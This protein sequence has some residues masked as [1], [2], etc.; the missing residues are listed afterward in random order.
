MDKLWIVAKETYRKNVKSWSF[1][2]MVF[3][4]LVM[5]GVIFAIGYFMG[6]MENGAN[7]GNLGIVNASSQIQEVINQSDT[8]LTLEYLESQDQANQAIKAGDIDGYLLLDDQSSARYYKK[9][10]VD[11]LNI[12]AIQDSLTSYY[13]IESAQKLGLDPN[14]VAQLEGQVF[15]IEDV[16]LKQGD[17]GTVKEESQDMAMNFAKTGIAYV[18]SF[19]VFLFIMNYVGI[20]SQEIAAEKGSRIMEI[21][22]SS[23]TATHHFMGKL[24]GIVMII[25]TQIAA[26]IVLGVVIW[27]VAKSQNL[28]SFL[29]Q[30]PFN[31]VD[32]LSQNKG[33]LGL[34]TVFA[35]TGVFTYT[36]LAGF[37]GSLVSK[38]E[39]VTKLITPITL[40][41]VAGFYIGM[42][43]L[44]NTTNPIVRIGSMFP[45]FTPFVMPF[46]IAADTVGMGEVWLSV[47]ISVVTVIV[48]AYISVLFYKNNVLIYSDKG[49]WNSLKRSYALSQ[50]E[51][52]TDK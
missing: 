24:L 9:A 1:L 5:M 19:V 29:D 25:L 51:K 40:L 2:W 23:I 18:V 11:S 30:L 32:L 27:F 21:I 44:S 49:I 26:Y 10:D 6:N 7:E 16:N 42:F 14:K 38:T 39:D 28:L 43:A 13:K 37:L 4:P 34:A 52:K 47:A 33:L 45:L 31:V 15:T 50:S 46:R 48:I 35:I 8:P 12:K 22:L 17:N 20:I 3:G 36:F 41:A